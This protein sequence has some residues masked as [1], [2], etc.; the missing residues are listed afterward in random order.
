MSLNNYK[1]KTKPKKTSGKILESPSK[2]LG[3]V[4]QIVIMSQKE[5]L[6]SF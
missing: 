6:N 3:W 5:L 1:K 2:C 4:I